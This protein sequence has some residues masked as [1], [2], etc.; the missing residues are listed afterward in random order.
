MATWLGRVGLVRTLWSEVRLVYRLLREPRVPALTK[1]LPVLALLYLVS[2]VDLVPDLIPVLGQLDDLTVLLTLTQIFRR[3][4]PPRLVAYHQSAVEKR[5][6]Y[7]PMPAA[8]D[9]IDAEW[10]REDAP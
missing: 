6:R 8:D 5:Q 10:R 1:A 4:V 9:V 3:V 2:P 7:A